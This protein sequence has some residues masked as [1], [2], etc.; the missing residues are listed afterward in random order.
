MES[1]FE[2]YRNLMV[3]LIMLLA[4]IIGLAMQVH[5]GDSGRMSLDPRDGQGVRLIRLWANSIVSPP[6]RFFHG[7]YANTA[8]VWN[9]YFDLRNAREENQQLQSTV[10]RLRL[11][12]AA[13]LEDARQG[14]RLQAMLGFQEKYVYKTQAAQIIGTSGSDQSRLFYIDK[15]ANAGIDRDDAVITSEGIVGK[16]REVYPRTA[17][18]LLINDQTSGAGVILETTRIRGILRGDALG[19]PQIVGLM[20]DSRIQ[21]GEQILTAGGDEI[22]P[23]GLPVGTVSKVVKDPD[24]DGFI[25]VLVKPAA[26]LDRLDEVLVITSVQPRFSPEQKQDI[27]VS[28]TTKGA[29]AEEEKA[30]QKASEVLGERLPGLM[31]PNLPADQQPLNDSSNPNP[32][33]RPPVAIRPDRFTP[34]TTDNNGLAVPGA[35]D[36]VTPNPATLPPGTVKATPAQSGT[37]T[38]AAK[39]PKPPAPQ[40]PNAA[41]PKPNNDETPGRNP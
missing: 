9:N 29:E 3:L 39:K 36:D 33:S 25:R 13:L 22:F 4:Q 12:E 16:V 5:R 40:S 41:A 18:V 20:A 8:F 26:H 27:A 19:Q 28:E 14:Q 32:V 17:Q 31:D 24:Q 37:T 30:Q 10:D 7:I 2:R 6:E 1:V 15:G 11:E 38:P 34:N 23:R 35:N 21:P